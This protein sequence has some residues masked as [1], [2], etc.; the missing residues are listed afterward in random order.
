MQPEFDSSIQQVRICQYVLCVDRP[1]RP[2][3]LQDI[4]W[5]IS[6]RGVLDQSKSYNPWY[7]GPEL[8]TSGQTLM[9][10]KEQG[11][12]PTGLFQTNRRVYPEQ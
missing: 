12:H 3:K 4:A 10:A 7:I 6:D 9:Y 11:P 8:T 5:E 1:D 2:T